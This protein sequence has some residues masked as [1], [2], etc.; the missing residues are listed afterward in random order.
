MASYYSSFMN[1]MRRKPIWQTK[2]Y[3][4][5]ESSAFRNLARNLYKLRKAHGLDI[6]T[7]SQIAKM[8]QSR[9]SKIEKGE[10]TFIMSGSLTQLGIYYKVDPLQLLVYRGVK[11]K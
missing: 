11:T 4:K 6:E 8:P 7:V 9:Y 3:Q 10:S 1:S 5:Y 2:Q